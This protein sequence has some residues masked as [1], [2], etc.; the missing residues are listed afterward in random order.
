MQDNWLI[1]ANG[2]PVPSDIIKK[3]ASKKKI[4]VCDGAIDALHDMLTSIDIVLGDGDSI[5][6]I[7]QQ[8]LINSSTTKYC[9]ADN[10][11]FS[12]LEKAIHYVDNQQAISITLMGALGG[13]LDH[14]LYNLR[15]LKRYHQE[16]RPITLLNHNET[17]TYHRNESVNIKNKKGHRLSIMGFDQAIVN[18]TDVLYP[19]THQLI[20]NHQPDSLSNQLISH[21]AHLNIEGY[22]IIVLENKTIICF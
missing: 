14:S 18:S 6:P 13:R 22:A 4:L 15:L 12:D 20:D 19:L 21:N 10:Q 9:P 8:T 5:S 3:N 17:I 2:E 1:I 11:N 16:K 7:T